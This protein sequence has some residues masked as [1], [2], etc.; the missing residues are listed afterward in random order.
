LRGFVVDTEC[1]YIEGLKAKL[2]YIA[3]N[4]CPVD[5]YQA[6]LERGWRRF[7]QLNFRPVCDGCTK[8]DSLR[9][10]VN[11]FVL[12]KSMKKVR[13]KNKNTKITI[14][15][16]CVS[17]E[18]IALYDY[19]HK[20]R[21]D[22]K[23]WEPKQAGEKEYF[24]MLCGGANEF[25]F[26]VHFYID[27]VLA[28]VDYIDIGVDGISAV[29]FISNPSYYKY[30]LGVFSILIQI[31]LAKNLGLDY[32]YLGYGVRENNSLNYKYR[33]E[34]LEILE[35]PTCFGLKPSWRRLSQDQ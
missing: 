25:A 32:I 22:K 29:Y 10:V 16:P 21:S 31:E 8:C 24:D 3:I 34:P 18:K 23:G 5:I 26:E 14:S 33:Y 17:N 1:S 7:G 12:S 27:D 35:V 30:S 6:F 4:E 15:K 2:E 13:L 20:E 11:E 19:Y 28:G 9:I